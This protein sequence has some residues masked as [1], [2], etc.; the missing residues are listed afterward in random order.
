MSCTLH[1]LCQIWVLP[2]LGEALS[3]HQQAFLADSS[4]EVARVARR[5]LS[6]LASGDL[7]ASKSAVMATPL[8]TSISLVDL[9]DRLY[10]ASY[11]PDRAHFANALRDVQRAGYANDVLTFELIPTVARRL[12]AAWEDDLISFAD[13]TI[14]CAR[15]QSALRGLPDDLQNNAVPYKGIQQNCLITVPSGAQHTMGA[16]VL[17]KQ[18]RQARQRVVVELEADSSKLSSLAQKQNF[19]V[20]LI[21]AT[22]GECPQDLCQFV[23]AIRRNWFASKVV[24]GGSISDLE[25]ETIGAIGAD[26]VTQDWREALDLCI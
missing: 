19:N 17:A 20:V 5:V 14:G 10:T 21:S 16:L 15:L 6:M 11:C 18:L 1:R 13:V 3:Q 9:A 8:L 26:H 22:R 4:G 24:I 12:G 25:G 7:G 2:T 23:G